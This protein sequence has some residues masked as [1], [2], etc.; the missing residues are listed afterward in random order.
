M[1]G[2]PNR[3]EQGHF[4]RLSFLL[5]HH[6]SSRA[7]AKAAFWNL[8]VSDMFSRSEDFGRNW[9]YGVG[10]AG[11]TTRV[12][13]GFCCTKSAKSAKSALSLQSL[14]LAQFVHTI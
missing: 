10:T 12:K 7:S 6:A 8:A 14:H 3:V 9:A 4:S 5:C 1:V 2:A 11:A 13:Q